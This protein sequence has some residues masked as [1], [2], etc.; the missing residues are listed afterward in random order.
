MVLTISGLLFATM[1]EVPVTLTVDLNKDN[2][3]I[4]HTDAV[5]RVVVNGKTTII[6][7]ESFKIT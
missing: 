1:K 6:E 3:T 2:F 4:I 7:K 5:A